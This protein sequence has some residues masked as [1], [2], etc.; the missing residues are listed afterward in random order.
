MRRGTLLFLVINFI[1]IGFLVNA[2]STLIS[3]LFIDGAADAIH[4]SE[5]PAPG[6]ELIENRTQLIPKII[7]QTYIN[8][9]IPERWKAGQQSC[10]ELHDDYEYKLWT[11][12]ASRAFIATE[13]PWFL[14]T[15]DSYPFP[16]QRADS[17]RYFVLAHYGGIY[18]DLDD[19]CKRRLD[20]L[21]SYP[22]W[23]RRTIPTGISNDAMGSV[24]Q[25]PFFLRVI[26][27][28]QAYNR[29][30]GMPYITVMYS[31]GPLFLSVLW[32][33]YMRTVTDE[34]GRVRNLMPDEYNKHAWSFFNIVKGNSWH[35]KDAQTIFWMGKH[36]F[37]LTVAG[38]A[39]AGVV[40]GFLWLAWNMWVVR[41]GK[42]SRR[43]M[44]LWRRVSGK[45][46]YEL[47]DRSV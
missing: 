30:W 45:D 38:F 34:A 23:L 5:I 6:S 3:L 46:R 24:P 21:L 12:E 16:I 42:S 41:S 8:E 43:G 7:H 26:E 33:E 40:G 29:N 4:R 27:S 22:A 9:S 47:L 39:I 37:L 10:I 2:F 17:I 18:I 44:A 20:P 13:Y 31:T 14:D 11:D 25:H 36:W 28:L 19:G 35:G 32:I 1:V 15:F